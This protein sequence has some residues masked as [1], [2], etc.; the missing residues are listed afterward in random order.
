MLP[1]AGYNEYYIHRYA[2]DKSNKVSI[3]KSE[4]EDVDFT[5]YNKHIWN[6]RDVINPFSTD[7]DFLKIG[8]DRLTSFIGRR[9]AHDQCLQKNLG[10]EY[11]DGFIYV[12][13][14]GI[15][16]DDEFPLKGAFARLLLVSRIEKWRLYP[17]FREYVGTFME[18]RRLRV[19]FIHT[20]KD[21]EL[22]SNGK[23]VFKKSGN[24]LHYYD[25]PLFEE[26]CAPPKKL[27]L[28]IIDENFIENVIV[29]GYVPE[30]CRNKLRKYNGFQIE[31]AIKAKSGNYGNIIEIKKI[32]KEIDIL[33]PLDRLLFYHIF[34][35]CVQKYSKK[36]NQNENW[37]KLQN[38][39]KYLA[40]D[41]SST[42]QKVKNEKQTVTEKL[43]ELYKFLLGKIEIS[44]L[45]LRKENLGDL[46]KITKMFDLARSLINSTIQNSRPAHKGVFQIDTFPGSYKLREIILNEMPNFSSPVVFSKT[47][48]YQRCT[49]V[50]YIADKGNWIHERV[51]LHLKMIA[52]T[53]ILA[54]S[55][56]ES[57]LMGGRGNTASGKSTALGKK[58][59]ILN[60]DPIK[61]SLRKWTE[62]KNHQ[63]HLEGAMIFDLCFDEI[64]NKP[65]LHYIVN[66]HMQSLAYKKMLNYIVDLRLI[67]LDD[68]K[69][70]LVEPA[71]KRNCTIFLSDFDVPL[72]TTL[73]RVLKRDPRGEDPIPSLQPM[74]EGFIGIRQFR[75]QI[76]SYVK[77]EGVIEEYT[78]Y[79]LG[80]IALKKEYGEMKIIDQEGYE[81]CLQVPSQEEIELCL[82]R[83]ID[84][85]YVW[86]A[87]ER[88]DLKF[89]ELDFFRHWEGMTVREALHAHANC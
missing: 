15:I 60:T 25:R 30:N 82:N 49:E 68:I 81:K 85:A 84:N 53:L 56:T 64:A 36:M 88:G 76:I 48:F 71:R 80:Q 51:G 12:N 52:N 61:A 57:R 6:N 59:G 8:E 66:F 47:L 77:E 58:A 17:T 1:Y 63:V 44:S 89:D 19:E 20:I 67:K 35:T 86:E 65:M 38:K 22:Y 23:I 39:Y 34:D 5:N 7:Y 87:S 70:Y 18:A 75:E 55:L 13:Q 4:N 29:K 79:Y 73:N 27:W 54:K 11:E 69:K 46:L 2:D 33:D 26:L 45:D 74:V 21:Y 78:L 83:T 32:H 24:K 43:N 42:S 37:I 31:E 72:L 41:K 16:V 50:S 3:Y 10:L 9:K 14:G 40:E 62:I 28:E